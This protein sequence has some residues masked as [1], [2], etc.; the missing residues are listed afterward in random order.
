MKSIFVM[1]V[2][3]TL[4]GYAPR[5]LAQESSAQQQVSTVETQEVIWAKPAGADLLAM[6]YRDPKAKGPLPV[7]IDV[8]GGAWASGDRT[9]GKLYD[10]ELA[11][12]GL[13]VIAIDF[14]QA[15]AFRH[16]A[17]SAD[18]AA[19]VRWV[20]LNSG[21][22]NADPDRIGLIGS[23]SGGHLA[24][25][26]ALRP[27]AA[28]HSGT[29]IASPSGAFAPHDDID[30]S[31][32]YVVAMWPVSD[33]AY[34]YR[35]AKRAGLVRLVSAS[36]SYFADEAAMWDASIPRIVTAGEAKALPPILVVQPGDDS[37]IPQEMT[38]DLLRAWQARG[39]RADYVFYPGESHAFGH[40]PSEATSDL[41]NTIADYVRRQNSAPQD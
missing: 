10:T 30:A 32:D 39:G 21:K 15:P 27:S 38:F 3:V 24:L 35:Y 25:L 28:V 29:P 34:R 22:L 41:V 8:H 20:R 16:P 26:E 2:L 23:S 19:A 31:V 13:L 36:E 6:I 9:G 12:S 5:A 4:T 37:N 7:L 17:A 1:L 14:R 11:K 18:V 40:R 33:P